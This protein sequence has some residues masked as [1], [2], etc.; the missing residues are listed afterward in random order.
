[1]IHQGCCWTGYSEQSYSS[2]VGLLFPP[3][4]FLSLFSPFPS[5][6]FPHFSFFLSGFFWF[7]FPPHQASAR[8]DG[9][10]HPPRART[11]SLDLASACF[12]S[13][14]QTLF[15]CWLGLHQ[16]FLKRQWATLVTLS[17]AHLFSVSKKN[18][19]PTQKTTTLCSCCAATSVR[20]FLSSLANVNE[21]SLT[22]PLCRREGL[23]S[24]F[25]S[26]GNW[27][28]GKL[29]DMPGHTQCLNSTLTRVDFP[30]WCFNLLRLIL[31]LP[32]PPTLL[33]SAFL[34]VA[35]SGG[36]SSCD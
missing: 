25:Y 16:A 33:H 8:G 5:F 27:G 32:P 22:M 4:F 23:S 26:W 20:G 19:N 13:P 2:H 6:F 21:L 18:P 11:L 36:F 35:Q 12:S 15:P 3:S 7:F 9:C 24:L 34:P 29:K 31:F 28:V 10:F 14:L 1:M 17:I 30:S